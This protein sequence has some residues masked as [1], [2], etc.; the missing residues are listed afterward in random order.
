M[1]RYQ[2]TVKPI[3]EDTLLANIPLCR[4]MRSFDQKF[5]VATLVTQ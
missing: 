5:N 3:V 1:E 4:F 2:S